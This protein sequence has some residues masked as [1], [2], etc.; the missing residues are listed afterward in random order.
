M[1][2]AGAAGAEGRPA[3][4][5]VLATSLAKHVEGGRNGAAYL[6]FN[7]DGAHGTSRVAAVAWL[8]A[9]HIA[10]AHQSGLINVYQKVPPPHSC[11]LPPHTPRPSSP[12]THTSTRPAGR[13]NGWGGSGLRAAVGRAPL[14]QAMPLGAF[15]TLL[16]AGGPHVSDGGALWGGRPRA[17]QRHLACRK[18]SRRALNSSPL[19]RGPAGLSRSQLAAAVAV[20]GLSSRAESMLA[21]PLR[22]TALRR[23]P[24]SRL[25]SAVR[26]STAH[27]T[28]GSQRRGSG[29]CRSRSLH[30]VPV[31]RYARCAG[32]VK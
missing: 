32:A 10:A 22:R 5:A 13:C 16:S 21:G 28:K 2:W 19:V 3:L 18:P 29:R 12:N 4:G 11:A 25:P 6:H 31:S 7:H 30:A 1:E 15:V 20:A 9:G 23:S 27:V 26:D 8:P 14:Q 17:V 24:G